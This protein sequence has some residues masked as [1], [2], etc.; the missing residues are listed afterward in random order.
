MKNM[1]YNPYLWPSRRNVRVLYKIGVD[2]H[3]GDVRAGLSIVPV[4]P[5]EGA[6]PPINCQFL[7]RSVDVRADD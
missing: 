5:W 3:D 4:I 1:Q 2:E 6:G 7:P